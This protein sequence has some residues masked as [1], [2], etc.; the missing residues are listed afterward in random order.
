[1]RQAKD[2]EA[3]LSAERDSVDRALALLRTHRTRS[4]SEEQR[5][6]QDQLD[7]QQQ[8]RDAAQQRENESV[9]DTALARTAVD[10]AQLELQN[11]EQ[12]F[13]TATNERDAAAA[14]REYESGQL[15]AIRITLELHTN[16][17][18][19]ARS[20]LDR[21]RDLMERT[22]NDLSRETARNDLRD[23]GR[24]RVRLTERRGAVSRQ[25]DEVDRLQ[26]QLEQTSAR[27]AT[28]ARAFAA[29]DSILAVKNAKLVTVRREY[30]AAADE[31]A[32]KND[33]LQ[34]ALSRWQH[35]RDERR[36]AE[37]AIVNTN[38]ERR[39][40]QDSVAARVND[41]NDV[42]SK[43]EALAGYDADIQAAKDAQTN[44]QTAI[45]DILKRRDDLLRKVDEDIKQAEIALEQA[46]NSLRT[47]LLNE[48]NTV[49]HKVTITVEADDEPADKYRSNDA[50]KSFAREL[51]Y[52]GSRTPNFINKFPGYRLP[53]FDKDRACPIDLSFIKPADPTLPPPTLSGSEPRTIALMYENGRKLWP[54]WPV[55]PASVKQVL[56]RDVVPAASLGRDRD[57]RIQICETQIAKCEEPPEERD[58]IRDLGT[59]QWS[60]DG[61]FLNPKPFYETILW[62]VPDPAKD[63][64]ADPKELKLEYTAAEIQADDPVSKLSKPLVE[65]GVLIEVPD[66]LVGAPKTSKEVVGRI[67]RGDHSGL[68][69]EDVEFSVTLVAG[70]AKD[71]GFKR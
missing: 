24:E 35:W 66:T 47:F 38:R 56:A 17:L 54:E 25:E 23:A 16:Q 11:K 39:A 57:M 48:F 7:R 59:Y 10:R 43:Q 4:F 36:D 51:S 70:E 1:M 31:L 19:E 50:A 65:P 46:E 64:C 69:G 68:G 9:L 13:E 33:D 62:Q 28:R 15:A 34:E 52:N 41:D 58:F 44:A 12:E 30:S 67:V 60:G 29:A 27:Q 8:E 63:L 55:I 71:Y 61:K 49:T 3:A 42:R 14:Q 40:R 20:E 18:T 5:E 53:D 6:L 2:R 26:T 32:A 45:A 22:Q 21:L 37:G